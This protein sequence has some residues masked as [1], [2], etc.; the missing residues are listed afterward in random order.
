[1]SDKNGLEIDI[2]PFTA[3]NNLALQRMKPVRHKI[4][5]RALT[6][7][8]QEIHKEI[9]HG[10]TGNLEASVGDGVINAEATVA[11]FG[12]KGCGYGAAVHERLTR[13]DGS[14]IHYSK[15]GSKSKFVADPARRV[16]TE[17]LPEILAEEVNR[18]LYR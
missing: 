7:V 2:T 12:S 9:P 18:G 11:E 5:G 16:G 4:L 17:E 6:R 8:I 15:V 1:M 10:L 3:A 14:P 13:K